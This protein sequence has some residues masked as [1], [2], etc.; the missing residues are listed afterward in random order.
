[1]GE[2]TK[3][4]VP[5]RDEESAETIPIVHVPKKITPL[6]QKGTKEKSAREDMSKEGEE[7]QEEEILEIEKETEDTRGGG[8]QEEGRAIFWYWQ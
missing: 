4:D 5:D 8:R 2:E 3:P 6:N 7:E 1:M